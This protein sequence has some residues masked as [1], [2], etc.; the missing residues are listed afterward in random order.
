ML[1]NS[2]NILSELQVN[3][4]PSVPHV[5]VDM[6]SAC[7]ES[8]LPFQELADI[9]SRDVAIASRVVSMANSTFFNRG[10]TIRSLDRALLVLGTDTIKTIVITA[11]IHQFFSGFKSSDRSYLNEFWRHSLNCALLSKSLA[12]LTSYPHPEEAYLCGLLHNLGE[13]VLA[14]NY[15]DRYFQLRDKTDTIEQRL[16]LEIQ[17]FGVSHPELGAQLVGEW[18]L[19]DYAGDAIRHHHAALKDARG[20]HHLT[21]LIFLASELSAKDETLNVMEQNSAQ[22]LF[23]L[24]ASLVN[25]ISKKISL[26]VNEIAESIGVKLGNEESEESYEHDDQ[27]AGIKLAKSIRDNNLLSISGNLLA[28]SQTKAEFANNVSHTLTLLFGY[29]Q[30]LVF[31]RDQEELIQV[32]DDN[33]VPMQF[34]LEEGNSLVAQAASSQRTLSSYSDS[35]EHGELSVADQQITRHLSAS[36]LLCLPLSKDDTCIAVI[37]IG[38]H[39]RKQHIHPKF[40]ELLINQFSQQAQQIDEQPEHTKDT[41]ELDVLSNKVREIAHEANNPLSIIN[42]YLSSLASKLG[43]QKEVQEELI[44]LREELNRASQIIMRLRD[45]QHDDQATGI[46]ADI[47][48]EINNLTTLYKNSLFVAKK[49]DYKHS[50]DQ[51]LSPQ[52]ISSNSLRQIL[53]NL[54]KN[55]VEALPEGGKITI[56]TRASINV[57]GQNFAEIRIED[58]GSGIPA[59]I[60]QK[61]FSPVL[62]TKGAGHSGLGLSITKNLVTEARGTITCRSDD[63]GTQF[64]ILLPSD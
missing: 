47:N 3:R 52:N 50:L 12:I 45:L 58:N 20:A 62:S 63:K 49:I 40:L 29:Q 28:S 23:E 8:N 38:L 25:E 43:D 31:W 60:Q 32:G 19:S 26:E 39:S 6:L 64:Q 30:S 15:N 2:Q 57:N 42:N 48:T 59:Q 4:L 41:Y 18:G 14:S 1:D 21:K 44:I 17:H 7:Q 54:I 36:E 61:L 37:A 53:T 55:A 46:D 9:I 22:E 56:S 5:L 27:V 51:S 16:E 34:T 24:N 33:E 35:K 11:S 13:L 10:S